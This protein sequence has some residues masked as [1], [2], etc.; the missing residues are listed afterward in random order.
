MGA[1]QNAHALPHIAGMSAP[2]VSIQS[3]LMAAGARCRVSMNF[4][5]N[6]SQVGKGNASHIGKEIIILVLCVVTRRL[7][8]KVILQGRPGMV[9]VEIMSAAGVKVHETLL[10]NWSARTRP[11]DL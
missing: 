8:Q 7:N 6:A 11:F 4:V 2:Y 9:A 10:S 5:A 1:S 3:G